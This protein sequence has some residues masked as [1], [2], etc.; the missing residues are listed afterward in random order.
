MTMNIRR[1]ARGCG[2]RVLLLSGVLILAAGLK[3]ALVMPRAANQ[4]HFAE[5]LPVEAVAFIRRRQPR[6]RLFNAYNGGIYRGR[7]RRTAGRRCRT[8]GM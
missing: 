4:K 8:R 7:C 3:V 1:F 6:G 5:R 2:A